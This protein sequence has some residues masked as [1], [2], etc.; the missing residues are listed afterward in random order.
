[1]F[2]SQNR[3]PAAPVALAHRQQCRIV[4]KMGSILVSI[5][6]SIFGSILGLILGQCLVQYFNVGFIIAKSK[7]A[8][9]GP[10]MADG[11]WKGV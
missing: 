2:S 10:K 5:L 8:A 4:C 11:V 9:R 1:M 6:C 3:S 7:M